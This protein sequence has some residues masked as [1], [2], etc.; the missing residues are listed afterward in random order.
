MDNPP[1]SGNV[2]L[3]ADL[4]PYLWSPTRRQRLKSFTVGIVIS[5]ANGSEATTDHGAIVPSSGP[6]GTPAR[7]VE[8]A[9]LDAVDRSRRPRPVA[10]REPPAQFAVV[11]KATGF[12][13]A[14]SLLDIGG[15]PAVLEVV[16]PLVAH[17][18]VLD[19]AEVDPDVRELVGE[20]RAGVEVFEVVELFH[21]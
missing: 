9:P 14:Y 13:I 18:G 15:P 5:G 2:G 17:E 16:D 11:G 21:S 8:E 4:N 10:R 19:A 1:G 3:N 20:Q 7:V 6:N 12:R